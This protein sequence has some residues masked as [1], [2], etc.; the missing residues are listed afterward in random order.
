[1]KSQTMMMIALKNLSPYEKESL[2]LMGRLSKREIQAYDGLVDRHLKSVS[3]ALL[4]CVTCGAFGGHRFYLN[5]SKTGWAYL[6]F[7][8]TLFPLCLA[9]VDCCFLLVDV[10][11]YNLQVKC[12]ALRKI[13]A[14][15]TN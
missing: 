13:K 14:S 1:M 7:S 11:R 5:Q 6:L 10:E 2:A 9:I 4:L 12:Q 15:P 8:W 3:E